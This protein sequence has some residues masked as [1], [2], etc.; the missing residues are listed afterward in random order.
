MSDKV[1]KTNL[2]KFC[3][4]F[5]LRAHDIVVGTGLSESVVAEMYNPNSHTTVS[6]QAA[7]AVSHFLREET[8]ALVNI[9]YLLGD[10]DYTRFRDMLRMID[11]H[12]K[13]RHG[14]LKYYEENLD[15]MIADEKQIS[16]YLFNLLKMSSPLDS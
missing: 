10:A 5:G 13:D 16:G 3:K 14:A 7:V 12:L 11:Q 2:R 9:Q 6:L 15:R 8:G 4:T 1:F